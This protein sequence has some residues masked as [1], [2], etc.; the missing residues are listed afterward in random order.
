VSAV[1]DAG[2]QQGAAAAADARAGRRTRLSIEGL[3]KSY[4]G[5]VAIHGLDLET[6]EGEFISVLGPSGCGKTTTLR[7]VAGF[8]FPEA[9]RICI[10]GQD[11]TGLPPEK[12]DIGMVFQ[13]YALFPHLTVRRNLAFGLEMRGLARAE[14][15]RRVEAVLGMVQLGPLAERYPRQLSGGQQQRVALARALVIEP[16]LLLLDEPL[17]NLDAV[18]REDMRVFIRE[19]QRRVGIT[20]LYVTHDQAEAMVMSDRVAV[21]LGGRLQQFD[22]PEAIYLRPQSVE[23]ARFIGRSNL[24]EGRIDCA[25]PGTGPWSEHRVD[26][27]LGPMEGIGA[28]PLPAGA[29]VSLAVRPEAIHFRPDGPYAGRVTRSYFLG[30]TVEH[31][32]DCGSQTLLVQTPPGRRQAEG[33]EVRLTF[34][35]GHAWIIAA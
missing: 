12:R 27:A 31:V 23:V 35:P 13:N 30:S 7:C 28:A 4:A 19:L 22:V 32:V 21:M 17:A 10:D 33:S 20:T 1:L 9:G 24:V 18:L 6:R 14:I 16:R 3:R 26:S 25:L 15:A 2:A 29:A 8:E 34:E 5:Q 11:I